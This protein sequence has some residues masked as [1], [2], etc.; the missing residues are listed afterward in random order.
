M[1]SHR[2]SRLVLILQEPL[3][4]VPFHRCEIDRF[5]F[6]FDPFT[7]ALQLINQTFHQ[8]RQFHLSFVLERLL[9]ES[10]EGNDGGKCEFGERD[11]DG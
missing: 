2:S 11:R 5:P 10:F 6:R 3:N 7:V 4:L 8:R 1:S 9:R